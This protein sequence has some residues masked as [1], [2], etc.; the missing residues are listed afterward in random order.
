ME[1]LLW[2][3][4]T[5]WSTGVST[6]F[7]LP[8][9]CL[10]FGYGGES[11][12]GRKWRHW[13][14][15]R[16]TWWSGRETTGTLRDVLPWLIPACSAVSQWKTLFTLTGIGFLRLFL[17]DKNALF[18]LLQ[19]VL[20]VSTSWIFSP[21]AAS[22][23][24]F[25]QQSVIHFNAVNGLSVLQLFPTLVV[26]PVA[27]FGLLHVFSSPQINPMPFCQLNKYR[28]HSVINNIKIRSINHTAVIG[29]C[30]LPANLEPA[31]IFT[32]SLL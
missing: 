24:G 29:C 3:Q 6:L 10:C 31:V 8:A 13:N 1:R 14:V 11:A 20:Q 7:H 21:V 25:L 22:H 4:H 5:A 2:V 30:F 16:G 18:H 12:A 19:Q 17:L 23:S 27:A 26:A 15:Q 32:L 28:S 9:S